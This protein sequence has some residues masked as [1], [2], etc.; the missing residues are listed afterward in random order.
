VFWFSRFNRAVEPPVGVVRPNSRLRTL[1]ASRS[2]AHEAARAASASC[3]SAIDSIGASVSSR[4]CEC[5]AARRAFAGRSSARR[6]WSNASLRVTAA[7]LAEEH[8]G[9]HQ[10]LALDRAPVLDSGVALRCHERMFAGIRL[11]CPPAGDLLVD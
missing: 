3:A 4:P 9:A 7:N 6:R 11:A 8:L 10:V 5:T 2:P 1:T